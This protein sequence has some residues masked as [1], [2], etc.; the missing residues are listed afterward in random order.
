M[1][2]RAGTAEDVP[3]VLPMVRTLCDL[4]QARDPER[5]KVRPD[6][7]D[8]YA[9]WLPARAADPRSVFLVAQRDDGTLAGF[10]VGTVEPEIPIFWVPEC[11]WVHD[12]WVEPAERG[13][14]VGARLV[15]AA[16]ERFG[17]IGVAQVRLHT[18]V[19]NEAARKVFASVGFRASVVEMLRP[20]RPSDT[21]VN[22]SAGADSQTRTPA[23]PEEHA[24]HSSQEH[25]R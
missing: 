20:T 13:H 6:V 19:F 23:P 10:T 8:R 11:G 9:A 25:A 24:G 2:I 16:V 14:G 17:A 15:E 3:A 1:V 21:G 12:V 18:G 7:L 5:F 4:H 22:P